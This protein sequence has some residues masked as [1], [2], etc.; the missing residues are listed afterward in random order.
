MQYLHTHIMTYKHFLREFRL[1][2]PRV[3][4]YQGEQKWNLDTYQH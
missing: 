4:K 2:L 3:Y 1:T